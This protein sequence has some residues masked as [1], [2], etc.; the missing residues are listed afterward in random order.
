MGPTGPQGAA[1]SNGAAGPTGPQGP[2][3]PTG[4]LASGSAA[5]NTPYWNGS[6]WVTSSANL[7]NNGGNIGVG[8]TSPAAKL[9]VLGTFRLADGSQGAGKTL[10]SDANGVASWQ[11]NLPATA[12]GTVITFV[13]SSTV[14]ATQVAGT[15]TLTKGMYAISSYHCS[16]TWT[17]N[18][19]MTEGLVGVVSGNVSGFAS[20]NYDQPAAWFNY[21]TFL[22]VF[23]VTSATA[24]VLIGYQQSAGGTVTVGPSGTTCQSMRVVQLF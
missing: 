16:V 5:G 14:T 13:T 11:D 2:Q 6:S 24:T 23:S 19:Y 12:G 18:Y 15:Y 1:G 9:D 10:R 21:D 7:F 8:T 17:P 3:G 4:L 22:G 20:R